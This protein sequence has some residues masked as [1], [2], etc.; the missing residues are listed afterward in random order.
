MHNPLLLR[1]LLSASLAAAVGSAP[2]LA[3]GGDDCATPTA[4]SGTGTFTWDN[5]LNTTS[6]FDGSD[7]STCFS[8][9]NTGTGSDTI[10]NDLF[11]VWTVPAAGN[12]QF[13]TENSIGN[14]DTKMSIHQG[15]DCNATC[16][17]SDDD[18]GNFP[19]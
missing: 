18:G 15:A 4:I 12:Y 11:F 1:V 19:A 10:R 2:A 13:D 17:A 6:G 3:Q 5:S 16:V 14:D 8:S 7:P 9:S